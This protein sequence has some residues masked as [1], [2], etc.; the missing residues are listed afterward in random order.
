MSN[1]Y[2]IG[3]SIAE[4]NPE[5]IKEWD[6]DNNPGKT[7]ETTARGSTK[8]VNWICKKGHRFSATPLHRTKGSGCPYCS[9]RKAIKGENDLATLIPHLLEEW[10]YE[11]NNGIDPTEIKPNSSKKVWWIC[12]TC[13][14]GWVSKISHR[15]RGS[16]CPFCDKKK[17]TIGKNDLASTFPKLALEWNYEENGNLK[18]SDVTVGSGKKIAWKCNKGHKWKTAVHNRTSRNQGCPYCSNSR[19]TSFPEQAIL[20]Y[21]KKVFPDVKDRFLIDKNEYDIYIPSKKVAIEY[22]GVYYHK[23]RVSKDELKSQHCIDKGIQIYRVREEGLPKLNTPICIVRK[24]INNLSSINDCVKELLRLLCHKY[25]LV[26]DVE[27]DEQLILSQYYSANRKRSIAEQRPDLLEE[28]NYNKNGSLTPYD[29]SV[30]SS[31]KVW[32]KCKECGFEWQAVPSHRKNG[33]GCPKCR[34]R[35]IWETRRKNMLNQ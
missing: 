4:T 27:E 1:Q 20:F 6:F 29:I 19:H 17:V 9:G 33:K 11:K 15:Y 7:P 31:K 3:N 10:D 23:N 25:D 2:T 21:V 26:I 32:W 13:G 22:D 24:D 12:S 18:P 28:W 34:P 14:Q 30:G 16:K 5:L 8:P 35:K